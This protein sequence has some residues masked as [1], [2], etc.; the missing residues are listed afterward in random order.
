MFPY[1]SL[2]FIINA[3]ARKSAEVVKD[4][5]QA[6]LDRSIDYQILKTEGPHFFKGVKHLVEKFDPYEDPLVVVVGG[7]G[8]LNYF[9]K[10][11]E[12]E[13]IHQAIAYLPAGTGNDFARSMGLSFDI[14]EGID[15]LFSIE[16]ERPL[17]VIKLIDH[18]NNERDYALN[19]LGFGIDGLT[20][21]Y[22]DQPFSKLK[23]RMGP[24]A[25]L[26]LAA[27]AYSQQKEFTVQVSLDQQ[28]RLDFNHVKL[29]VV[30]NNPSFGGGVKIY[31]PANNEDQILHLMV[32]DGVQ[33]QDMPAILKQILLTGEAIDHPHI[34]LYDFKQARLQVKQGPRGQRDGE[35]I[36]Q[37]AYDFDISLIQR[38]FWL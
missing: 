9:V 22:I 30:L 32:A 38:S 36:H 34:H 31:P 4:I 35:T 13:G 12:E 37:P 29:C 25:Y 18:I 1:T 17:D 8:T 24:L 2:R 23:K 15:R 33:L 28:E 27:L 14:A 16:K 7:D 21:Y 5:H 3:K 6:M 10:Q 19:S 20:N 11:M 26:P